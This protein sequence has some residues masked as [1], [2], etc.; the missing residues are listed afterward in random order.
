MAPMFESSQYTRNIVLVRRVSRA[1]SAIAY[2]LQF[3]TLLYASRFRRRARVCF[4]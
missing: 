2:A 4:L 3:T 1:L